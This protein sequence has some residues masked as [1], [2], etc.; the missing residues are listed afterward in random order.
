MSLSEYL[1]LKEYQRVRGSLR[2]GSVVLMRFG[3]Y[4]EAYGQ[5]AE[6][7]AT[8]VPG[9]RRQFVEGW[10]QVGV[11]YHQLHITID[12][13]LEGGWP[14]IVVENDQVTQVHETPLPVLSWDDVKAQI[15]A[16]LA[17]AGLDGAALIDTIFLDGHQLHS[18]KIRV[19]IYAHVGARPRVR[20]GN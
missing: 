18:N 13:L 10:P 19:D 9:V 2:T 15:E 5:D 14:V 11:P 16:A 1:S 3:D 12:K 4:Y 17:E 20:V 7:L 8:C 6:R